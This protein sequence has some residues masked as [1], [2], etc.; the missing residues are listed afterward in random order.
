MLN[1]FTEDFA[2][3]ILPRVVA[4]LVALGIAH[5]DLLHKWGITVDWNTLGGKATTAGVL[6]IGIAAAHHTHKA[7]TGGTPS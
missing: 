7:I 5:T 3:L 4:S 2:K 1:W 6:L